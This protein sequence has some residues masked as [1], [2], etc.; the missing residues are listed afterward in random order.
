MSDD[1]RTLTVTR[2]TS[3]AHRLL[4]YDGVCH[5]VHGHNMVWDLTL[6]VSMAGTSDNNMP[7]D[8]KDVSAVIDE[9]DHAVVLNKHDPLAEH[10]E[11]LGNLITYPSDPTTELLSQ[12]VAD[13]LVADI[14][15]VMNA[16]VALKETEKYG[17]TARAE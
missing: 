17:M 2:S 7:I 5:N 1:T 6:T 8:F 14:D 9:F 16:T 15:G 3:T 12:S 4:N 11:L 10:A 13:R